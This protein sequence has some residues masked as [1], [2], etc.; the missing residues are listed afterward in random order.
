MH[1]SKVLIRP[2]LTEKSYKHINNRVYSLVVSRNISKEKIKHAF[3]TV[4]DNVEIEKINTVNVK[5]K[6]KRLGR[7][8]P[9]KTIN[10]KKA[11]IKLKVG[12]QIP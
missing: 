10:Y 12:Y 1:I 2:F 5:P 7:Y 8:K 9:G 4:F 3:L 6:T 11:F